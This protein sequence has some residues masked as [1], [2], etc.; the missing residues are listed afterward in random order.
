M[1]K[2]GQWV[3]E[4]QEDA[5][6]MSKAVFVNKHGITNAVIWEEVQ[7]QMDEDSVEPEAYWGHH[8]MEM[9]DGA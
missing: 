6:W 1:S 7:R 4:M 2:V 8:E 5:Q 9:D 3:F